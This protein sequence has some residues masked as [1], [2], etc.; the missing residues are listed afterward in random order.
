MT[1][2]DLI[3]TLKK[4]RIRDIIVDDFKYEVEPII[5]V[6]SEVVEW[7]IESDLSNVDGEI[8]N[9]LI[10]RT[11]DYEKQLKTFENIKNS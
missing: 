7:R 8:Y 6:T 3:K 9:D 5:S 11:T 1:A 4:D 10:I 2:L